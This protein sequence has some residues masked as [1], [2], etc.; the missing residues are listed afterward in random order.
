MLAGSY[1][2]GSLPLTTK[3]S[4]RKIRILNALGAGLLIGTSLMVVIPEGV[5]TIYS[6]RA[7]SSLIV[8][9]SLPKSHYAKIP[10]LST[11]DTTNKNWAAAHGQEEAEEDDTMYKVVTK[12]APTAEEGKE[13]KEEGREHVAVGLS[14]IIGFALMFIIDQ[15]SSLHM[16]APNNNGIEYSE[17]GAVG[18]GSLEHAEEAATNR[19]TAN[20]ESI[21]PDTHTTPV[22]QPSMTPTVGL[23]V[24]AAADGIALGASASHPQLSMVVFIAIMLHKAPASF[25]LTS[26]LLAGGLSHATIRK[27]L[28]FFA[29]AAPLGALFTYFALYF[30]SSSSASASNLEYWTGVLLVFSGGTFLYVAMHALQEASESKHHHGSGQQQQKA[31]QSQLLIILAGMVIPIFLSM[32]HSH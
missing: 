8:G 16:T 6:S 9:N 24:H 28:L 32:T 13:E 1:V 4:D 5:E 30:F 26:L 12:R 31:D 11:L 2:A 19:S 27:H 25:A 23:V 14:L 20:D 15:V 22:N 7:T 3:L 18:G 21:Y 29:L 10:N 17:L